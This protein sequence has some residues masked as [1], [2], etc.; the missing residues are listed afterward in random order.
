[1]AI[2]RYTASADNTITNAFEANLVTRGTGSNMGYADSLE[3]FSIYG[4]ESGSNGQ[5]QELS[6]ILIQFPVDR[7]SSDR[8]AGTIPASGSVSFY[9]KMFN[10]EHPFTLPQDFNLVVAPISQSWVEGSGLDMDEYQDIGTSNWLK[11]NNS[12]SWTNVGGDY[13]SDDNYNVR[14][15]QGYENLELDV[16]TVVENWITGAVGNK[17]NNY[18]FGLRL[19]ASQEAYFSSSLGVDSGSV[20]QNTVG[21]TQSYYTKKFFAR[22][23]EFFFKR[24][25]IEARWDSRVMDDRENFYFS[26]SR[27][28]AADNLNTLY[29]Y[30]Y[31]R[32]RLR[33][34]PGVGT[35]NIL[36]SFY[37]S[38]FGTPAGSKISLQGG[39][40]VVSTGDT[41]AT[42]SYVSPG[43]YSCTVAL[44]AASTPL[45]EINDV[46][47]SGGVEFFTG[48]FFPEAMPTYDSAPTFTKITSCKNLKKK[49]SK[50]DT[51]RFRFFVRDRNWSPTIYTVATANNP[52]DIIESASYGIYRVIDNL[53]AVPYGTGSDFSTY[54]SYDKEGNY[55]DLD[56]S[57][58]EPDYMYEIRLSYYNDSI[59]DWQEQPQTFKFRVEE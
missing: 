43:I 3:V 16:T 18:G 49:Y 27:A 44:T 17:Y 41:N 34:I 7:I 23:S 36:V 24:P 42:G 48:S 40:S 9:L 38:S 13:L 12:T 29:F 5:S 8:T 52:T 55:F 31:V 19:T 28:P 50:Q 30:N 58:L 15:E 35:G 37:S 22:S 6:R 1:M 53:P 39:G 57:L 25:V 20:I 26:S 4:Q 2:L 33:N 11:A 54:L 32:G 46:W 56:M 14:F 47:H 45:Q 51:A 59:G 10:A 21:A